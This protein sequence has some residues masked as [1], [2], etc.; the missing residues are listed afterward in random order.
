MN[1]AIELV[2]IL[3]HRDLFRHSVD[4]KGDTQTWTAGCLL[5][6]FKNKIDSSDIYL[7]CMSLY[8]SLLSFECPNMSAWNCRWLSWH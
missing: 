8:P 2:Q 3:A 6:F 7:V 1:C 5:S 4:D